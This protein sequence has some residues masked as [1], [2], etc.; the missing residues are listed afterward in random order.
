V[1]SIAASA[2][3][4]YAALLA[5][6]RRLARTTVTVVVSLSSRNRRVIISRVCTL[7]DRVQLYT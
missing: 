6:R 1:G 2:V 3:F 5:A 7:S 4:D